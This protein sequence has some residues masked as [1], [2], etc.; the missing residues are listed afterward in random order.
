[1]AWSEWKKFGSIEYIT[2]ASDLNGMSYTFEDDGDY[3][4]IVSSADG[5]WANT[6]TVTFNSSA[7]IIQDVD[8]IRQHMYSSANAPIGYFKTYRCFDIK[9]GD[10]VNLADASASDL[11]SCVFIAVYKI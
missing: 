9:K 11:T 4:V 8:L 6:L 2:S 3:L 10:V 5:K 7:E 1:M